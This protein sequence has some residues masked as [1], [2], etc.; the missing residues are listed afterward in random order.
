MGVVAP[1]PSTV[2]GTQ[3]T[4]T[5]D[6]C[7][8]VFCGEVQSQLEGSVSNCVPQASPGLDFYQ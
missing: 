7:L 1:K 5:L 8:Q 3:G 6:D 4:L 2:P